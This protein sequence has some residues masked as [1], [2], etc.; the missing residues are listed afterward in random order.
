MQPYLELNLISSIIIIIYFFLALFVLFLNYIIFAWF[1][2][3]NLIEWLCL[4][5]IYNPFLTI[6]W[7]KYSINY[8]YV[9]VFTALFGVENHFYHLAKSGSCDI[10]EH[11]L[12]LFTFFVLCHLILFESVS[13]FWSKLNLIWPKSEFI[14]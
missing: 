2:D 9:S 3:L 11:T 4:F 14:K 5:G 12:Y 6:F 13:C 8:F 10:I 7:F 1:F